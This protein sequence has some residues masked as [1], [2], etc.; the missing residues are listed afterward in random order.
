MIAAFRTTAAE[1][2]RR[3]SVAIG[4]LLL[5]LV[6]LCSGKLMAG[7]FYRWVDK[8]G[9]VHVSDTFPETLQSAGKEEVRRINVPVHVSVPKGIQAD[10][11]RIPFSHTFGGGIVVQ[12]VF[13]DSINVTLL[14]DTGASH[15]VISETLAKQLNSSS[16]VIRKVKVHTA[17]GPIEARMSMITKVALG[18]ATKENVPAVVTERDTRS[19]GFDAILGLSFLQDFKATVDHQNR[20][21]ILKRH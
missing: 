17:G 20:V 8:N 6:F 16:T 10:E 14:F 3:S 7:E 12:G 19:Q 2:K 5:L 9:V 21:I 11:C 4:I 18:D 1:P 15:M 13:D